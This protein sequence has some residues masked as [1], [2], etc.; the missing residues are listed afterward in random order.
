MDVVVV[1]GGLGNQMS[2]YAFYL[3]K[4]KN[5]KNVRVLFNPYSQR[6][7]NGNE[8]PYVFGINMKSGIIDKIL[9]L[10]YKYYDGIPRIRKYFHFL[11]ITHYDEDRNYNFE[12]E[13]LSTK[14]KFSILFFRGGYHCEKYF[15]ELES[16]IRHVFTFKLPAD[17]KELK[18]VERTIKKDPSSVSVHI[19]RGDYINHP[20]FD[21]VANR[22]YYVHA[23]ELIKKYIPNPMFYVFSNDVKWSDEFFKSLN[24]KYYVVNLGGGK[25]SYLDMYLMTLCHAHIIANSTFSWWGAWLSDKTSLTICPED[26]MLNIT[27]KDIYPTRWIRIKRDGEAIIPKAL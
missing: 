7:H 18:S 20:D 15:K 10:I 1:S 6:V 9:T 2:Q 19:R 23:I 16:N 11:R 3:A 8:L 22:N 13:I 12:P 26:F 17:D 4:K 25:K 27:T 21:G 5:D 14:S 24:V